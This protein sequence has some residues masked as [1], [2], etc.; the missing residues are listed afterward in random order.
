MRKR[1][2]ALAVAG[3]LSVG[4]MVSARAQQRAAQPENSADVKALLFELGNGMGMLRGLQQ[5]IQEFY[6]NFRI[7]TDLIELR[8]LAT[9]AGLIVDCALL[10]QESRGLHYT[11]DFP[12]T[13]ERFLHPTILQRS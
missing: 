5:E 9:V 12:S 1:V 10:R 11:L 8:N 13:D 6:W 2:T 4:L 7:T 3:V